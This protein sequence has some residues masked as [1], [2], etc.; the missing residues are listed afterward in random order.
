MANKKV[1]AFQDGEMIY[2]EKRCFEAF[3]FQ[4]HEVA[5]FRVVIIF[6][7]INTMDAKQK[8]ILSAKAEENKRD[9]VA[10]YNYI[11]ILMMQFKELEKERL[12][13]AKQAMLNSV[14]NAKES[15]LYGAD[16]VQSMI[17][18]LKDIEA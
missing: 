3:D 16:W 12:Q 15:A 5:L 11:I 14:D 13:L 2:S 18:C 8:L 9:R 6:S 1:R 10:K 4:V 7:T 17:N